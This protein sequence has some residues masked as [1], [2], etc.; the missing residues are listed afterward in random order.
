LPRGRPRRLDKPEA[1][2]LALN[3]FWER[4][5]DGVTTTELTRAMGIHS[6]SLYHAFGDKAG[7]FRAAIEL[8]AFDWERF[9]EKIEAAPTFPAV[10]ELV[11][12]NA[13]ERFPKGSHPG[14]CLFLTAP[15]GLKPEH[16]TLEAIVIG[17]RKRFLDLLVRRASDAVGNGEL[18]SDVDAQSFARF[19]MAIVQGMAMQARDGATSSDLETIA[20]WTQRILR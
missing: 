20:Q 6:P 14:G 3:L 13:V 11:T 4:G 19:I 7:V 16:R 15:L 12:S 8:Y 1:V 17:Y 9:V 2:R 18:K 10:L 5:Y